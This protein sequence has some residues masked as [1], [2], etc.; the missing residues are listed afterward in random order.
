MDDTTFPFEDLVQAHAVADNSPGARV[1]RLVEAI[2]GDPGGPHEVARLAESAAMSVRTLSRVFRRE[3]GMSPARFVESARVA[4]ARA[5][6]ERCGSRLGAIATRTGF[7]SAERMR[8]A[9]HRG[10][11]T[12]PSRLRQ[13]TGSGT[14]RR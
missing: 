7:A 12:S 3:T 8:R 2:L 9:F 11:G 5:L 13:S 1:R 14:T 10:L 6:I 4:F